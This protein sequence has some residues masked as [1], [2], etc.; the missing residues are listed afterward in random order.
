[1]QNINELSIVC[2]SI[3]LPI[4]AF[5][6]K[7]ALI[8]RQQEFYLVDFLNLNFG[9]NLDVNNNNDNNGNNKMIMIIIMIIIIMMMITIII[10]IIIIITITLIY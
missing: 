7:N 8:L 6:I 5:H 3:H 1:M 4:H 9:D 2:L 10:I